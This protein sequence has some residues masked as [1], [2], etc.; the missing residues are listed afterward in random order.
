[1]FRGGAPNMQQ[2]MKQMQ[3][4]QLRMAKVQEELERKIITAEA[5]GGVVKVT[6]NGKQAVLKIEINPEVINPAEKDML[7]DLVLTAVN[8][9]VER[10]TAMAAEEMN[11]FTGGM[12]PP[13]MKFPGM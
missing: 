11:K 6:V 5:G 9:A 1:M 10:S 4:M 12:M 2:M 7:E 8:Q 3:Q 13:G